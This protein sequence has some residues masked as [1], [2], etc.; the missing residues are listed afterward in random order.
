MNSIET[1]TEHS[2]RTANTPAGCRPQTG[3]PYGRQLHFVDLN[4]SVSRRDEKRLSRLAERT[5][6]LFRRAY[7]QNRAVSTTELAAISSQY[8]ARIHECRRHLIKRGWC[9]DRVSGGHG[10]V[11]YYRIRPIDRSQFVKQHRVKLQAEG[12]L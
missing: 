12:I 5:L 1:A 10:G 9:I 4:P 3:S 2:T 11:H 6:E 7:R 8:G